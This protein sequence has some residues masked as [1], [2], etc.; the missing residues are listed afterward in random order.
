MTDNS[1]A[2]LGIAISQNKAAQE[3]LDQAKGFERQHDWSI[4]L[5]DERIFGMFVTF[6]L[7]M[8][9]AVWAFDVPPL[10]RYAVTIV[11][12]AIFVYCKS[13]AT[14]RKKDMEALRKQQ[15]EEFSKKPWSGK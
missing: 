3:I 4:S 15:L 12:G 9:I 5:L 7:V 10:I 14:K 11:A 8:V 2:E 6:V 13:M 1:N